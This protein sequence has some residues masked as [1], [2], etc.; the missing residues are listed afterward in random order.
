MKKL[1]HP[2]MNLFWSGL[3][4]LALG[5]ARPALATDDVPL[6]VRNGIQ[7][8]LQ[9]KVKVLLEERNDEGHRYIRGTY[10]RKFRKVDESTFQ[11]TF[12]KDTARN[13]RMVTERYL[14]T[15]ELTGNRWEIVSEEI[16]DS[17]DGLY[18]S[19]P[20]D[21]TFFRFDKFTFDR[22][23]FKVTATNG[24]M[25]QDFRRGEIFRFSVSSADLTYEYLPP[26]KKDQLLYKIMKREYPDDMILALDQVFVQCHPASCKELI[27]SSFEGIREATLDDVEDKHAALYK[28]FLTSLKRARK[29]NPFSGFN[30]DFETDRRSY[31]LAVQ[32]TG[33]PQKS[34][35]LRYDNFAPHE[36]IFWSSEF[37]AIYA[38]HSEAVRNSKTNPYELE[39]RNDTQA[40]DFDLMGLKGTVELATKDV[41]TMSGDILFSLQTKRELRTLPFQIAALDTQSDTREA[42]DPNLMINSIEDESG[43]EMS[44]VRLGP[45]SGLVILP[46]TVPEGTDI[47]L[48][49]DFT[50]KE[51]ILKL[52]STYSF[53]PREGWLPFVRYGDLIDFFDLTV[54]VPARYKALG[55]GHRASDEIVEGLNVTRWTSDNPVNFPTVIFGVYQEAESTV[56]A[57][58]SDGTVIPVTAYLDKD[59]ISMWDMSPKFLTRIANQAANSLNLYREI[60]GV[61]YPFDKLDLV[62]D[63]APSLYGQAPSSI[64]FLGQLAFF[65]EGTLQESGGAYMTR[66]NKSLVAHEVAHQWWG[67]SIANHNQSNY[68]FVE[69]LAEYSSAMYVEA[70]FGKKEYKRHVDT[71]RR[72]ILDD[73]PMNSVQLAPTLWTGAYQAAVYAK[74]P[75]AFHI[76]R[77]TVGREKFNKFLKMLAQELEGEAI[78]TRDI[79]RIA[80]KAFGGGMEWF[81]DQWIRGVGM[82]IL[83]V[84]YRTSEAE[85]GKFI[86]E[87]ELTQKLGVG[88]H[89]D[90]L[91]DEYF[92]GIV[93][94]TVELHKGSEARLPVVLKGKTTPFQFTV[95]EKPRKVIVNKYGEMLA[96]KLTVKELS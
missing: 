59:S 40:R 88:K 77:E 93:P 33:F 87:G 81:F 14:L 85:D 28:D 19:V 67:N 52:T 37:G 9:A 26:V 30:R 2:M 43:N 10:S 35:G 90:V 80:E 48:R 12:H 91:P 11:V 31:T 1:R 58:K 38:Y 78:V 62:N 32:K 45:F 23:G 25:L 27:E 44:Y 41:E 18:R 16:Q 95:P 86:V 39:Y 54:K 55:V 76:L 57:T 46:E 53:L 63:P 89:A 51:M 36:V 7:E 68:W 94:I 8:V 64:V 13:D 4:L 56:E 71:W 29:E 84:N 82:P 50:N 17:F 96:Q 79:Q 72:K 73:Q 47:V 20:E 24:S 3:A 74:G 49:M 61:D 65:G 22:E 15:L 92:R 21:E 5:V 34:L 75:Y 60:F 66:F 70:A 83:T 69:S 6:S 42:R